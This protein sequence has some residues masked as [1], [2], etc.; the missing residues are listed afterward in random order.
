MKIKVKDDEKERQEAL[1][2]HKLEL[3][4]KI[5]YYNSNIKYKKN[6]TKNNIKNDEYK[7]IKLK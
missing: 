4:N 7:S 1:M 6:H 2:M 3:Y 5:V